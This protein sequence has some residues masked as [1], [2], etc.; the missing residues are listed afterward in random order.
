VN[1]RTSTS[2]AMCVSTRFRRAVRPLFLFPATTDKG[3]RNAPVQDVSAA[4]ARRPRQHHN[5]HSN[6]Q[7]HTQH[8]QRERGGVGG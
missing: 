1:E 3:K 6:K 8:T 4:Q 7:T 5:A 2:T